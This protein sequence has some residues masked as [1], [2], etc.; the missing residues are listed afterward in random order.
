MVPVSSSREVFLKTIA[1][2][3]RSC[4]GKVCT[5]A[6]LLH[7]ICKLTSCTSLFIFTQLGSHASPEPSG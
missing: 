4:F 7:E 1:F 6:N 2:V 3:S 5:T